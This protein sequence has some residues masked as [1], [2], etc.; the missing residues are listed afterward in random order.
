MK[1]IMLMLLLSTALCGG[2]VRT[3]YSVDDGSLKAVKMTRN[4]V[5][6]VW[7]PNARIRQMKYSCEE[8]QITLKEIDME[9]Q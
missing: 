4:G 5:E 3:V 2:C 9:R 8:I 7:F 1:K 6:G